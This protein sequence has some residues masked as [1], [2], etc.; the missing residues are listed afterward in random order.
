MTKGSTATPAL[1]VRDVTAGYGHNT[2]LRGVTITVRASSVTALL[3]SNGAGKTT[4]LKSVSGLLR[5][6]SGSVVIDGEDVSKLAP[7]RR[8]ERGLCHI[9][10][11]R[12]VFRG[13]T[14]RDNLLM[15]S[16]KGR[17]TEAVKR[18]TEAF[19]ILGQRMSQVAG[20]LSGGEQQML[21][22]ARA[23]V[24]SPRLVLVDEASLGLAPVVVDSIFEFLQQL[25]HDGAALL[26][27]DQ[28]VT[29]ALAMASDAYILSR[30]EIT[31]AGSASALV[32]RDVFAEYIG[33]PP[34]GPPEANGG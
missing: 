12:A 5:P 27:V 16:M 6:T 29:R 9:P 8:T 7:Y 19:P 34:A 28:F 23:Y 31:Y 18:A 21:A 1:E 15:H 10:E 17:E 14:V 26:I 3:G 25:A 13:L 24:Q 32:D 33:Q 2:V 11:G 20:T 4:L 30:G 22:I